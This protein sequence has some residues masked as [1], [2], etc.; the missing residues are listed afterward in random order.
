MA[1]GRVFDAD[2]KAQGFKSQ[3]HLDDFYALLDHRQEC[4][5]CGEGPAVWVD[6]CWQGSVHLCP[7]G[8]ALDDKAMGWFK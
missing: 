2:R 1:A 6:D 5:E 8:Q 7:V 4:D 3:E